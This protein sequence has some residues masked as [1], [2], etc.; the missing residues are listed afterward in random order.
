[1]SWIL[2]KE[3]PIVARSEEEGLGHGGLAYP[4]GALEE[5]VTLGHERHEQ[6]HHDVPLPDNDGLH[7]VGDLLGRGRVG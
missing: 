3:P 7:A 6:L 5:D 1:M 4:R 2:L